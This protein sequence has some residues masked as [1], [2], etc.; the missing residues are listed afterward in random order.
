MLTMKQVFLE[1]VCDP[2]VSL[3]RCIHNYRDYLEEMQQ[4][5]HDDDIAAMR[6]T[7]RYAEMLEV[8]AVDPRSVGMSTCLW[9]D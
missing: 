2:D 4:E 9:R 6:T 1:N 7:R 8:K 3:D 5:P